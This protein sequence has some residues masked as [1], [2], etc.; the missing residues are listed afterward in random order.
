MT[1]GLGRAVLVLERRHGA[2][3]GAPL[4]DDHLSEQQPL[5][6]ARALVARSV[7]A[8]SDEA[9]PEGARQVHRHPRT[10]HPSEQ[11]NRTGRSNIPA[12]L[13]RN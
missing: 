9:H 13:P 11:T 12:R 2:G 1:P 5:N 8:L 4:G 7:G 3:T 10:E 6:P